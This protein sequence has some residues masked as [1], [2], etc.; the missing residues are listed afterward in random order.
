MK[1][2]ALFVIPLAA[3]LTFAGCEKR[4]PVEFQIC[5]LDYTNCSVSARFTTMSSCKAHENW[6]GMLCDSVSEPGMMICRETDD[7]TVGLCTE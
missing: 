7:S 4:L 5:D 3:A 2:I 6:S 1:R